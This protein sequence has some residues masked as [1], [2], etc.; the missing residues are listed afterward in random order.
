MQEVA[1]YDLGLAERAKSSTTDTRLNKSK[2]TPELL[3]EER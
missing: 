1:K 3:K 2:P